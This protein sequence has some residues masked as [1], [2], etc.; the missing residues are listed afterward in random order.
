MKIS[1]QGFEIYCAF[2]IFS[3]TTFTEAS[4]TT[5]ASNAMSY[6]TGEFGEH[7]AFCKNLTAYC[8]YLRS[9]TEMILGSNYVHVNISLRPS[10]SV[11]VDDFQ[12]R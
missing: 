3:A 8:P 5:S 7:D 1:L 6:Q 11:R 12:Q 10:S 2:I 9:S 4:N